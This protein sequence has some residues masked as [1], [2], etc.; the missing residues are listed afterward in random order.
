LD[1]FDSTAEDVSKWKSQ[2]KIVIGYI[3]VGTREDWNLDAVSWPSSAIGKIVDG[4]PGERWLIPGQW[5]TVKNVMSARF[6]MLKS[7]GFD[8]YE[9][10]NIS[11]LDQGGVDSYLNDNI[12]YAQWLA[13][14]AH[15]YGLLA[16][17]KNGPDLVPNVLSYYD[18]C[19]AEEA[20]KYD[21]IDSYTPFYQ[22]GKPVW[23]FEYP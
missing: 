11:L 8:G 3:S 1:G 19:F 5:Q 20:F 4:W 14:T 21:E 23:I 2:G 12:A 7:K 6:A 18:G 10:D 16:I 13:T 15:S 9:G 22:S 17:F